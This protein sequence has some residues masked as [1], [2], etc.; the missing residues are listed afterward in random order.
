MATMWRDG[1]GRT[2]AD[3][4]RP[5]VAVDVV[6][7]TV[8]ERQL[9]V[10]LHRPDA[11]YAAGQWCLPGTFVRE[12]E[13]LADAA[14]RAQ[15][16]KLGVD[17]Q[18]PQQLQVFD[19]L[20]R[21]ERGRVLTVAHVDVVPVERLPPA[22]TALPVVGRRVQLPDTQDHLPYDHDRIVAEAVDWARARHRAAPDP[23]RLLG[24]EFT[25]S[26]LQRLHEAVAGERLV[27]DTFRRGV[28]PALEPTGVSRT[29]TVGRPAALFRHG[30]QARGCGPRGIGEGRAR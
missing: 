26:D 8:S 10:L 15:R 2:L 14:R 5:S 23:F 24:S 1:H 16:E 28:V 4:P 27:K 21:D 6:L 22:C 13:L 11:G 19:A 18:T 3:H 12:D 20:D 30:A 17:G 25:L 9:A 29:G 7:L